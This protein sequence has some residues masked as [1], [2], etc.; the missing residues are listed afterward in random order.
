MG[1]Y[2]NNAAV[3]GV[4]WN[5]AEAHKVYF[6]GT[7]VYEKQSSGPTMTMTGDMPA[8]DDYVAYL[9]VG[10]VSYGLTDAGRQNWPATITV[11]V[12][13]EVTI[14]MSQSFTGSKAYL[15]NSLV[16][17]VPVIRYDVQTYTFTT[18]GAVNVSF[19]ANDGG[20]GGVFTIAMGTETPPASDLPEYTYSGESTLVDDGNGNWRIKFLTSG[21]FV[22]AQDMTI[23]AF[24]VGGGGGGGHG[25]SATSKIMA[26][27][28]GGGRT[29]TTKNIALSANKSYVM[30]VGAGGD[31]NADGGSTYMQNYDGSVLIGHSG[32]RA[33]AFVHNFTSP[34][35]SG[36][37]A[38][39]GAGGS[40]GGS[41]GV[42]L[43]TTNLAAASA[44]GSDGNDGETL[45]DVITGG[46][47][48]GTTTREFGESD[49]ALYAGGGGAAAMFGGMMISQAGTG[50]GRY[51]VEAT[52]NTGGGGGGSW[53]TNI[54][55]KG[56]SG[57]III[58]NARG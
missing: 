41:A 6:N 13:T 25:E 14:T 44:G 36:V 38:A 19:A 21:T 37:I 49:G 28:G 12:G 54:T 46:T 50:G 2:M 8:S 3:G 9:T 47:G 42:D 51:N 24:V 33:G 17:N 22:P 15:N 11:P 57:I 27:G 10:G 43:S 5:G 7:L 31:A 48:Q 29:R 39:G 52:D 56:G 45:N 32:G 35:A 34:T 30:V 55:S 1:L 18:T 4:Y 26:S 20:G 16:L 23:D 58:R 53:A 40:G